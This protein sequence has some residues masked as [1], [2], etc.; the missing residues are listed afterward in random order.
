MM[1]DMLPQAGKAVLEPPFPSL[2]QA[3]DVCCEGYE[4]NVN[5]TEATKIVAQRRGFTSPSTVVDKCT[6]QI[7]INYEHVYQ[8]LGF[9]KA[10]EWARCERTL[11]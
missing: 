6:R 10:V 3:L 4:R 9:Q 5:Y 1:E 2:P 7:G 8:E 11:I